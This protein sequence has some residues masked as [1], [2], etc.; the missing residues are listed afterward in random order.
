MVTSLVLFLQKSK[1][2]WKGES[3]KRNFRYPGPIP[4]SK[5]TPILMLAD[6][7]EAASEFKKSN[8]FDN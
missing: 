2:F 1:R 6:S 7:V 5:E 4:F 3:M 8:F